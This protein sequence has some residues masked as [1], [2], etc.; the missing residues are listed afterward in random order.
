MRRQFFVLSCSI[1]L[2]SLDLERQKCNRLFSMGGLSNLLDNTVIN[3]H[4][5]MQSNFNNTSWLIKAQVFVIFTAVIKGCE[6]LPPKRK[7]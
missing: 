7:A 5:S 6:N 2:F 1:S 3:L 4:T